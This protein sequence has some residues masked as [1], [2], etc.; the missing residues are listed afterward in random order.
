MFYGLFQDT[1]S[2]GLDALLVCIMFVLGY[3]FRR[4][5]SLVICYLYCFRIRTLEVCKPCLLFD[6]L[7]VRY[8]LMP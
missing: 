6:C 3:E 8:R 7:W 1:S 5:V 2:G 4:L